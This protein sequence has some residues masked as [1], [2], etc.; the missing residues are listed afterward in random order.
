MYVEELNFNRGGLNYLAW[1]YTQIHV[2]I[3]KGKLFLLKISKP[4]A[5]KFGVCHYEM[6]D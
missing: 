4:A 1:K 2:R 6:V 5:F 3:F